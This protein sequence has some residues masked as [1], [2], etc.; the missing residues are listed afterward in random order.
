LRK[1]DVERILIGKTRTDTAMLLGTPDAGRAGGMVWRY[2][3]GVRIYD[4]GLDLTFFAVEMT[5]KRSLQ[6]GPRVVE[7]YP[8]SPSQGS[9]S[10]GQQ[11]GDTISRLVLVSVPRPQH[12]QAGQ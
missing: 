7:V 11:M 4:P 12:G 1:D 3:N 2:T 9:S 5:F 10:P 8:R 6:P